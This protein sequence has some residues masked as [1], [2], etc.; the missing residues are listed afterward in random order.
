MW[1]I[2]RTD[3]FESDVRSRQKDK[4]LL[5]ALDKKISRLKEDPTALG[6]LL[7]GR[8]H[9]MKS[10]RLVSKFRLIFRVEIQIHR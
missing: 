5:D 9:G 1:R 10:T 4:A 8:L 6:K 2:L 3:D 7:S